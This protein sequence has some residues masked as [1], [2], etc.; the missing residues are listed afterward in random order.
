MSVMRC[1]RCED[2]I[3]TDF[4]EFDFDLNLCE[5]CWR[6]VQTEAYLLTEE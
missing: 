2:M 1:S 4:E 5:G 3:D 6:D